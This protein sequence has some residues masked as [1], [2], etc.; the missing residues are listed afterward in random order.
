MSAT[1]ASESSTALVHEG[2]NHLK[3]QR[4]LAA[5]GSWQ[6]ALRVDPDSSAAAQALATLES[7]ADLPLAA[8]TA[9]RF[10][11]PRRPGAAG[12][13]GRSDAGERPRGPR[14]DGRPVRPA[15]GGRSLPIPP[16]GTTAP[17][18]WPGWARTSRRSPAWTAWSA[19]RRRSAFDQAVD[20]WTLAEVLRQ[21]GGAETLADDL[22]FACTIAWKPGDTP[23]LLDE[24]PEIR[25]IPTPRA[26][27]A[28]G[29]DTRDRGIRVARSAAPTR[30]CRADP[31]ARRL[32][33]VL[34]S[35]YISRQVAAAL[36]PAAGEPRTDRGAR[37]SPGSR[38]ARS[39]SGA[40]R[41]RCRCR[42]SM[43]MS[44]SFGSRPSRSELGG[45]ARARGGRALLRK[46]LDSPPAPWPRW[47]LA[48]RGAATPRRGDAVA[49]AKLTAVVRLREQLGNRVSTMP[50]T[51]AIRST[52]CG[53]DSA[54]SSTGR[55][56]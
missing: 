35:V 14:G 15:G 43:P 41:R 40:K 30:R 7:A 4:P 42:F 47:P 33:M 2:W 19:S 54:W 9:Y 31:A 1:P 50:S 24:F 52:G 27:G 46:P 13:L 49:R 20:A 44:G 3:S 8:R 10:R 37:S 51:R 55:H 38:M 32:P 28:A 48:A 21:G 36:E 34:A 39:R 17:S 6:R 56:R 25:R 22:R 45:P 26:P 53:G 23:W 16:P 18:A 5:W 11:E 29:E 12:G